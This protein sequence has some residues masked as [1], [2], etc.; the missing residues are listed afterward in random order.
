MKEYV[1]TGFI[2]LIG[3]FVVLFI[4]LKLIDLAFTDDKDIFLEAIGLIGTVVGGVISGGLTLIGV[5]LTLDYYT[6]SE[7]VDQYPIKI[8]KIHRLNN[9]LKNLSN[10]LMKY[11]VRDVKFIKKEIDYLLDEASEIDSLIFSNIVSI[12]SKIT[13]YLIPKHDECIGKDETGNKVFYPSPDYL[14]VQLSTVDL[15]DSIAKHLIKFKSKYQRDLN[16]YIN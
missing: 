15:I 13:N 10:Y 6:K 7:K 16:K 5:K 9:R 3:I 4:W 8:R 14:E 1:K 11:E 2:I 12:E